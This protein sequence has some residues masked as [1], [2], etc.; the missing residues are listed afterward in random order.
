MGR[1]ATADLRQWPRVFGSAGQFLPGRIEKH[2]PANDR[3]RRD[4]RRR[5]RPRPGHHRL[6][7]VSMGARRR[8]RI[9]PAGA[10]LRPMAISVSIVEDQEATRETVVALIRRT[11]G[12][13]C[14]AAYATGEA[15]LTG[16]PTQM[17][18]VLL[19]DIRLPRM[20]GIECVAQLKA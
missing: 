1:V 4:G 3:H 15:A 17:P 20:S 12:L 7:R 5:K 2:A 8:Q 6:A 19:V 13:S 11:P 10:A 16:V 9:D 14:L 18:D